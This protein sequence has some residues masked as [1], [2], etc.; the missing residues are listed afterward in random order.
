MQSLEI[1]YFSV[2]GLYALGTLFFFLGAGLKNERLHKLASALAVV[3]FLLHCADLWDMLNAQTTTL[4]AANFYIS[5][6][7]WV[8]IA[9]WF[10]LWWRFKSRYLGLT[11]LPLALLLFV[12]S[13]ATSGIKV[14]FPP[15]LPGL[16][17]GLHIGS[18]AIALGLM[19]LG[20]GSGITWLHI[21][22]KLKSK[23]APKSLDATMPSLSIFDAVNHLAITL[24]FPLYTLGI[25]SSFIWYWL[26]PNRAFS[27][28]FMKI[29]S[30]A[31]WLFFA[32][33][34]YQRLILGWKGRKPALLAIWLFGFLLMYL[35]HHTISFKP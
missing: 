11:A 30:L 28:D 16:F 25:F 4:L 26:E 19:A 10:V 23:A 22:K 13:V 35:V 20:F 8:L 3:G 1:L 31:V 21:N 5:F 27:W 12:G 9:L 15:I 18:L 33:A 24:G 14:T 2:I 29:S 6:L 32:F 7:A 34:F 17:F